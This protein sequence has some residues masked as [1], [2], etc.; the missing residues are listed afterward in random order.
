MKD[1][2]VILEVNGRVCTVV[3]A[4]GDFRQ[5]KLRGNYRPGQEITLPRTVKNNYRYT[6][7]AACLFIFLAAAGIWGNWMNPAVAAYVSLDINPSV[8]LALDK[9]NIVRGVNPLNEDGKELIAGLHINGKNLDMALQSL[10]G[11]AITKNYINT[12]G[13]NVILSAVTTINGV[14]EPGIGDLIRESIQAYLEKGHIEAEIVVGNIPPDTREK[15]RKAGISTGRYMLFIDAVK[16]E[17]NVKLKD[18]TGNIYKIQQDQNLKVKDIVEGHTPAEQK[19]PGKG[20]SPVGGTDLHDSG[21]TRGDA[22]QDQGRKDYRE[23]ENTASGEKEAK[24]K[25]NKEKGNKDIL[26]QSGE[27]KNE[28]KGKDKGNDKEIKKVEGHIDGV[29][30]KGSG[31]ASRS[32]PTSKKEKERN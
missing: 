11:V 24:E 19:K 18:F 12:G 1:K 2:A 30:P 8:E 9:Q 14:T 5:L 25:E 23:R 7:V 3:T 16:N 10:I 13:Q 28:D 21:E 15:A 27:E 32:N 17:K 20:N 4:D 6:L 31:G 29:E 22:K 26:E